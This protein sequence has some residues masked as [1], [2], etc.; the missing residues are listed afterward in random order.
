MTANEDVLRIA[1][2]ARLDIEPEKLEDV[3]ANFSEI[4]EYFTRLNQVDTAGV[5]PVYHATVVLEDTMDEDRREQSGIDLEEVMDN[6]PQS[7]ENQFRV[8]KV[9][10]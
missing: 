4:L 8:P 2:L 10:E 6:A 3:A 9:I 5:E 1:H 7:R